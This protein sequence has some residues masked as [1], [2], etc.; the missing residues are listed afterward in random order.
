MSPQVK[1]RKT[2]QNRI[3]FLLFLTFFCFILLF[4]SKENIDQANFRTPEF[5]SNLRTSNGNVK[6]IFIDGNWSETVEAYNWCSG[7]GEFDD[8]YTI[9]DISIN[10]KNTS[11]CLFIND[12]Q[13]VFFKIQNCTFYNSSS[14][15]PAIILKDTINGT[16]IDINCEFNQGGGI[17]LSD[18][19]NITLNF[20]NFTYNRFGILLE[21]DCVKNNF[22]NIKILHNSFFGINITHS[23]SIQNNFYDNEFVNNTINANDDGNNNIW[24]NGTIGNFW[25]DYGEFGYDLN[26]DG[27]GDIPYN[28]TGSANSKDNYPIWDDCDDSFPKL[29]VNSPSNN[30]KSNT[31]PLIN[32]TVYDENLDKIWYEVNEQIVFLDNNSEKYLK[33]S[34]WESIGNETI[35]IIDFFANDTDGNLN[36]SISYLLYKDQLSP[37]LL[38][39]NP[40]DGETYSTKPSIKAV[41]Y[42]LNYDALWYEVNGESVFLNNNTEVLLDQII[43]D[44]IANETLFTINFF[45]ND[46]LGNLNES[47]A[48]TLYKDELSPRL[49][50]ENPEDEGTYNSRPPIKVI[51]YDLNYDYLWYEVNGEIVFLENNTEVLLDQNIWNSIAN[52]TEFTIEFFANDTLGN[53][54][55]SIS[56]LLYKDELS[57]RLQIENPEDGETYNCRPPIEVIVYDPNYD[58]LWYEINGEIVFLNNNT[59]VLLEQSIWDSIANETEFTINFFANDTLGNLNESISYILYKDQLGPQLFI[60]EPV[61]GETYSSRPPI[62]V[63]VYDLN[64]DAL[65]YEVNGEIVFLDNNTQVLLDQIIWDSIANETSFTI[66]FFA[67]DTLGNLNESISYTLYKDQLG[68][69]LFIEEPNDGETY[70][71]RPPIKVT[72][73]DLNYDTCWYEVNGEIVFLDN[74]TQVLLKESIW[75]SITNETAFIISFFANDTLGNLNQSIIYT[76]YKDESSPGL[77]IEEPVN[78]ETYSTIPPIKVTVY[79]L[80]YDALW[81]EVNGEI[82]FLINNTEVLLD[83]NIWESIANE[84]AFTIRFYANDTLGNL[85]DSISYLLYKDELCPRLLIENPEDGETYSSRPPIKV[86][87]YDLNY[88]SLWYEVNGEIVFLENNTEVLLEDLIWDSIAN[89]TSFTINFFAND[90]LGNLNDAVSYILYKDQLSP[91]LL[92]EKPIDGETYSTRPPIKVTV[93]DLNYDVLWYEENGEIVFLENNTEVLLE[94]LIWDSIANE[95]AFTINFFANDTLG[96]LNESIS[97]ILY[98][99]QLSPRLL[100]ENP[101]DGETYSSRP[102]IMV[103]VYDQNYD[104]LWYEVNGE[105]VFLSNNTEVLLKQSIWD[106]IVNETSFTINFYANDTLGHLNQSIIYTLYKDELSPRLQIENPEDGETYSTRPPIKV[107]VYDLN[108]DALWYEVNGEIVFLINNTEVLLKQSIW[109]SITNETAFTIEFFTN[110][111]LGNLNEA[112][113]YILYKDELSPRLLIEEPKDGETYSSRPPIKVTVYDLNYDSLWYEVN[114]EIVFLENNTQVLLE[115]SIWDS[116]VNETSFTIQFF[117]NDTLGNLNEA[118]SYTLFKDEQSPR[119]QI[120][121]PEDGKTYNTKPPIMVIVYDLNYDSLW[122]EVNGEIV[123]L[124]NNTEVLLD[125]IIWDLITNETSFTIN[126]YANDTQG[127]FNEAISYT[128]FKD[129]LSPRLQ[130]ENPEDGKTYSSRPPIK[131]IV[132][133]LNYDALWYEVNEE[134]VFLSNNTEVLL[135][136]N[137]WNSIANETA[138]TIRFYANDT[139]GNLNEV[140]SYTLFKDELG[141][142]IQIDEP[143]DGET[144]STRPPIKVIVY[145]LNLDTIWYEVNGEIVFLENNT[146]V[147][148][149]QPIWNSIPD[150]T[151]F[152]IDFFANDTLGNLNE[153][154]SYTLF[155]DELSP[156]LQIEN[157]E[158]RESYN[159]RPLI[160]VI[161][162]DLNFDSI[163]YKV[164]DQFVFLENNTETF[165]KLSIWDSL[166]NE[167]EFTIQFFANDTLG[168]FNDPIIYTIYKDLI[169]PRLFVHNP[170]NNT[171]YE[172]APLI[173]ISVNDLY[174]NPEKFYYEVL[175]EGMI[176]DGILYDG[177]EI[178]LENEIWTNLDEGLFKIFIKAY[179]KAGNK[180]DSLVFTLYKDTKAPEIIVNLPSSDDDKFNSTPK[181]NFS[182]YDPNFNRSWYR[183]RQDFNWIS[184]KISVQNNTDEL[185]DQAIWEQLDQGQFQ[186]YLF[187]NDS[188][189]HIN[190]SLI[191]TLYKDDIVPQ[192]T[193]NSPE[194]GEPSDFAPII[195][196]LCYDANYDSLW[197]RVWQ[198]SNWITERITLNNDTDQL[199]EQE[200][201]NILSEGK[202]YIYFYAND[203]FGNGNQKSILQIK[204][205]LAPIIIVNSP[206]E[207]GSYENAPYINITVYDWS[208]DDIWYEVEGFLDIEYLDNN[209]A[210]LLNQDHFNWTEIDDGLI[211]IKIRADDSFNKITTVT[212]NIYKDTEEPVIMINSPEQYAFYNNPPIINAVFNDLNPDFLWYRVRQ[213]FNWK[214]DKIPLSNNTDQLLEQEIWDNQLTEGSFYIYFYANDTLGHNE[215]KALRFNKD[216]LIP[217]LTIITPINKTFYNSRPAILVNVYDLNY[218]KVWY[219]VNGQKFFLENGVQTLMAQSIWD[220]LS[221]EEV[222]TIEFYANDS[223]GNINNGTSYMLYKDILSPR[224]N[225]NYPYMGKVFGIEY[226]NFGLDLEDLNF[227]YIWYSLHTKDE[228]WSENITL[229]LGQLSGEID[230]NLWDSYQNGTIYIRF[231]ANDSAGNFDFK[232]VKIFKDLIAPNIQIIS[233]NNGQRFNNAP[234][235]ILNITE[236]FLESTWYMLINSS[237]DLHFTENHTF[238]YPNENFILSQYWNEFNDGEIRIVFYANDSISHVNLSEV[239]VTKDQ[240]APGILINSP[241]WG[242]YFSLE[243]PYFN[244]STSGDYINQTWYYLSNSNFSYKSKNY[245]FSGDIGQINQS[246]W[247]VFGNEGIYIFFKINDSLN[248]Q[249][250][251]YIFI[252][253]DT[254]TPLIYI[255]NPLNETSYGTIP[256]INVSVYDNN[257]YYNLWYEVGEEKRILYNNSEDLLHYSI[258]NSLPDECSF[259]IHFFAED[260]AG[261]INDS[262]SYLLYKDVIEPRLKIHNPINNEIFT[263]RPYFD[264]SVQDMNYD[265]LW[266]RLEQQ[267]IFLEN[268]TPVILEEMLW[269][270]LSNECEF[271]ITIYA[272]DTLGHTH[273]VSY[274][275]YK[276]ILEPRLIIHNPINKTIFKTIFSLNI[277][278]YDKN[279]ENAWYIINGQKVFLDNNTEIYLNQSIWNLL[280]AEDTFILE[281]YA[282]DSTGQIK[283]I[284]YTLY[285]DIVAPRLTILSPLNKTSWDEPFSI[286]ALVYDSNLKDLYYSINGTTIYLENNTKTTIDLNIWYQL[287]EGV[288]ELKIYA[289]DSLGNLNYTIIYIEI[290]EK[291]FNLLEFLIGPSGVIFP[292]LSAGIMVPIGILVTKTRYY[293]SLSKKEKKKTKH[294]L[295][296]AALLFGT[297]VFLYIV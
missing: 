147:L 37:R 8:P 34:I 166:A 218:E 241:R 93:Y 198:N 11:Y 63:I 229:A 132:Y 58:A 140:I 54:N 51:V 36:D 285:K 233:P 123:F 290:I 245:Y 83:Q 199:L 129:E 13:D 133:D 293:K 67:N 294:V 103:I 217:N 26:D 179:D 219:V 35:F 161:V 192:I 38:I 95:T 56:Y 138:F 87:V 176:E 269:N 150:E 178:F 252:V 141:P 264:I 96:N 238:Q 260:K 183:V 188:F 110:D 184:D 220:S 53:L 78:G 235:F 33:Q 43:W 22:T 86:T 12:S 126:F 239:I 203:T 292:I 278:I 154:I 194:D 236:P 214:S 4:T 61:N 253:K 142:R 197:Y 100:I 251:D 14:E 17:K 21:N 200:V 284:S 274:N 167:T 111:T 46:T 216:T 225:I 262:I 237:N 55:E 234:N 70:S 193:I 49:I 247:N 164:N 158:N 157:P 112:V 155:K 180:N 273:S 151:A 115:Q 206:I 201:W 280:A 30:S 270:A 257:Y 272:N 29:V 244:V 163:W 267:N 190:D 173:K 246:A 291:P 59:E 90:T 204:D 186:I 79:D 145:D 7:T 248:N 108:L 296:L 106:S 69:Q 250:M 75:D 177:V 16:L 210:E 165:L 52:E 42:D 263:T 102:P 66:E 136:Q 181:V 172:S 249:N 104:A 23:S 57:P 3:I 80:N 282:N 287:S 266:Y 255:N 182:F 84:T 107:T 159:T 268:N 73:Y 146:E 85:N 77:S 175:V 117:A 60:E 28:I 45:A 24:D 74:N 196:V 185:L 120:E 32:V 160:K 5:Y 125:Q 240:N 226:F 137:I 130:I 113:S 230:N 243:A 105:I 124:E 286:H 65:W 254:F 215:V 168:N 39:E 68:P 76:L 48:Y 27:I 279:F 25:D 223:A 156:R 170:L 98:K 121:N 288:Y 152:T 19:S 144:Y 231:Y 88:D 276:D 101:E 50:I 209:T 224:I 18:C 122:Y 131:V 109:D 99:D 72:V 118:I 174:F 189:N 169:P 139:L 153:A 40:E 265:S 211:Q 143:V 15:F 9:K 64:Y 47:I 242:D 148:L 10:G 202:Y 81:Y 228:G 232:Q 297:I 205:T 191:L 212:L 187:A 222:F 94:D 119:L 277:S 20:I 208:L 256:S 289:N 91:R 82:V 62:K 195:N 1:F 295:V 41:V 261:N 135:D 97:Y 128:L 162:Y 259:I 71:S 227:Q 281:F 213:N 275:L 89:E 44:S 207:G 92:V 6:P 2:K 114:G 31:P 134:I 116:I 283:M 171:Y 127:N 258:W 221:N 271:T 149:D